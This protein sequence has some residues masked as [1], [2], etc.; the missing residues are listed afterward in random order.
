MSID[1]MGCFQNKAVQAH[2]TRSL[3]CKHLCRKETDNKQEIYEIHL[4]TEKQR[5]MEG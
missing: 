4:D 1:L 5:T 3:T 2:Y